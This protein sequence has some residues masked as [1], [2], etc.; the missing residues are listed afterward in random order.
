MNRV[1]VKQWFKLKSEIFIC[2][3]KKV[4]QDIWTHSALA[5]KKKQVK[6]KKL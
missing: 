4:K 1:F 2:E 5:W 6:Q 3:F